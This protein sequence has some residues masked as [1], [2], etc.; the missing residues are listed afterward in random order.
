MKTNLKRLSL[1]L[2]MAL[3]SGCATTFAPDATTSYFTASALASP[4]LGLL[5]VYAG[6]GW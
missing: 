5:S 6:L 2:A 1:C 3:V 4:P